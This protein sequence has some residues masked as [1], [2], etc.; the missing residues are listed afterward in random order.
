MRPTPIVQAK[1]LYAKPPN[2]NVHLIQITES[3]LTKYLVTTAQTTWHKINH[4]SVPDIILLL[5]TISATQEEVRGFFWHCCVACEIL[6]PNRGPNPCPWQWR[7]WVLIT[8]LQENSHLGLFKTTA[9]LDFQGNGANWDSRMVLIWRVIWNHIEI[10]RLTVL[11]P[12]SLSI[13]RMRPGFLF[14]KYFNSWLVFCTKSM[15]GL[16]A[17]SHLFFWAD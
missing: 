6:Y 1:L 7:K 5:Y 9:T 17:D 10:R 4:P 16:L 15:S 11:F 8:G 14:L 3:C 12:N 2:L 13:S